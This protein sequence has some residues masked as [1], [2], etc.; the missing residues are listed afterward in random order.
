MQSLTLHLLD[1]GN[2]GAAIHWI[3]GSFDGHHEADLRLGRSAQAHLI[4]NPQS[5]NSARMLDVT[6]DFRFQIHVRGFRWTGTGLH[7]DG[8][9]IKT[10]MSGLLTLDSCTI[11]EGNTPTRN[12]TME[13]LNMTNPIAGAIRLKN[14]VVISSANKVFTGDVQ[15]VA[16]DGGHQMVSEVPPQYRVLSVN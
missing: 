11:G 2:A 9:V 6:L 13:F 16:V 7:T 12:M 8:K 5:E 1:T 14:T 15:C 3:G 10:N 4:D